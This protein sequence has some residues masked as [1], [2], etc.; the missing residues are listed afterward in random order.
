MSKIQL[1]ENLDLELAIGLTPKK[2][3]AEMNEHFPDQAP[4]IGESYEQML[5]RAGQRSVV[6]WMIDRLEEEELELT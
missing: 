2:L 1:N 4:Q 6:Q 5:I 3:L